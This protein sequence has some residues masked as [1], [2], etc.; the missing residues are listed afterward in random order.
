M[1]EIPSG[2]ECGKRILTEKILSMYLQEKSKF[3]KKNFWVWIDKET[4]ISLM[5]WVT[6]M[7]AENVTVRKQE[8][9]WEP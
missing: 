1:N 3:E 4:K 5:L 2:E 8:A 9:Q 7:V 6:A